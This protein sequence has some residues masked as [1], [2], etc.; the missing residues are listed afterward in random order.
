MSTTMNA[1]I[2]KQRPLWRVA[3]FTAFAV[4]ALGACSDNNDETEVIPPVADNGLVPDS[5]GTSTG[6][7][8]GYLKVLAVG[9]ETSEPKGFSSTFT[10]PAEDT[11]EPEAVS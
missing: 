7:F 8:I 10:V 3:L 11:S 4:G 6:A 5:V 1:S 9:D 2:R